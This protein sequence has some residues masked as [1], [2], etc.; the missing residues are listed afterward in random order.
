MAQHNGS[1]RPSDEELVKIIRE[2]YAQGSTLKE[3]AED[4]GMSE[5]VIRR[6]QSSAGG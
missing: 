3:L 5:E 6:P 4:L 2:H 1:N